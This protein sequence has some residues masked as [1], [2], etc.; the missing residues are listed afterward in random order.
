MHDWA[1]HIAFLGQIALVAVLAVHASRARAMIDR[2]VAL[3]TLPLV[4]VAALA[5][6]A[7]RRREP[8]YLDIALVLALVGFAATVATTRFLSSREDLR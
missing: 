6:V 2:A 5:L 8:A 4:F 3:D 1:F 7:V